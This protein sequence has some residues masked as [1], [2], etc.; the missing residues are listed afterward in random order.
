MPPNL[1]L[2]KE[3]GGLVAGIDEAGRGPWA[4]PVVAAAVIIKSKTLGGVDDSKKLDKE[5]REKLFEVIQERCI[6]G[7]GIVEPAEIDRLDILGATYLAM[8]IALENLPEKPDHAIID[9]NRLPR[10]LPCPARTLIKGDAKSKSVAAASII[11]KVTR[12]RIMQKLHEEFP[13]YGW[14]NNVGYG[15]RAHIEGLKKHGFTIH[16]RKSFAPVLEIVNQLELVY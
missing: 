12:D 9:G 8:R 5:K 7:V 2:E 1:A 13:H 11:A 6:I 15:T 3:L 14:D 4:G 10:N 16:H